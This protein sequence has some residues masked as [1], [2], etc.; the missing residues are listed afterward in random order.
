MTGAADPDPQREMWA[1]SD[2]ER[3]QDPY[4][5]QTQHRKQHPEVEVMDPRDLGVS[6]HGGDGDGDGVPNDSMRRGLD[7]VQLHY[8][9]AYSAAELKTFHCE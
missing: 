1:V 7:P 4:R 8:C 9:T 5:P 3:E 2:S 6:T